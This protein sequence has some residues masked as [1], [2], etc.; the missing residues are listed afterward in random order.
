MGKHLRLRNG[1]CKGSVVG[2]TV[3][4]LDHGFPEKRNP[5]RQVR[6]FLAQ[7]ASWKLLF[8][9][10][11]GLPFEGCPGRYRSAVIRYALFEEL[12][13]YFANV[14]KESNIQFTVQYNLYFKAISTRR[15]VSL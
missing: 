9:K 10:S 6:L 3:C 11:N 1:L 14:N 4:V 5:G 15:E 12:A 7:Q 2:R 13:H 8:F